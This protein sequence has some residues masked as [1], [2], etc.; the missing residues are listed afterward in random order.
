M[1]TELELVVTLRVDPSREDNTEVKVTCRIPLLGEFYLGTYPA[2]LIKNI[3]ITPPNMAR[4]EK[5][6]Y[7]LIKDGRELA[8]IGC[9]MKSLLSSVKDLKNKCGE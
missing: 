7:D 2:D 1:D 6:I 5:I 4:S 9:E 3:A 8:R